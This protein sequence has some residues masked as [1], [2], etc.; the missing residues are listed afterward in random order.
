MRDPVSRGGYL[1]E[2]AGA[3]VDAERNF[4]GVIQPSGSTTDATSKST[5]A[6]TKS[7]VLKFPLDPWPHFPKLN[8]EQSQEQSFTFHL[9]VFPSADESAPQIGLFNQTPAD[10]VSWENDEMQSQELRKQ[11]LQQMRETDMD[12]WRRTRIEVPTAIIQLFKS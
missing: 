12:F 4:T 6:K 5:A 8:S 11:F 9:P 2:L 10:H 7:I 1:C 3:P